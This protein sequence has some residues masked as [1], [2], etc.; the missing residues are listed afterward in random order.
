MENRCMLCTCYLAESDVSSCI[1]T[2]RR[3]WY[4][5]A[6]VIR[7]RIFDDGLTIKR[8]LTLFGV[9]S[10]DFL[11]SHCFSFLIRTIRS[12]HSHHFIIQIIFKLFQS[13]RTTAKKNHSTHRQNLPTPRV[14]ERA[15]VPSRHPHFTLQYICKHRA[16]LE[17]FRI[18]SF[19][20]PSVYCVLTDLFRL[21]H[22]SRFRTKVRTKAD[23]CVKV[24]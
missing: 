2:R 18:F 7:E 8:M 5:V 20:C 12:F 1:M 19:P 11:F 23:D 22:Y 17:P 16:F 13:N 4:K 21:H 3:E 14:S 24:S 9:I 6:R 15:P 10:L